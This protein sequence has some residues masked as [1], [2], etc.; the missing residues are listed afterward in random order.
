MAHRW[1]YPRSMTLGC[2]DIEIRKSEFVALT[3]FLSTNLV[4]I[5]NLDFFI[6]QKRQTASE[7]GRRL[8]P[9][10]N[11]VVGGRVGTKSR[12]SNIPTLYILPD[13]IDVLR[14]F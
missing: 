8:V 13:Y 11:L 5:I 14:Y 1:K 4:F 10:R 3:R 2:K 6:V 9:W 12:R 7:R